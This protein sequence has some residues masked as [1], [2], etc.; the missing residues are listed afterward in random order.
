MEFASPQNVMRAN[1]DF[2]KYGDDSS[3][4]VEFYIEPVH[5]VALSEKEG[6]ALYEDREFIIIQS[7]GNKNKVVRQATDIDKARFSR[8]FA[9]FK[10][11]GD[12]AAIGLPLGEWGALTKAQVL[13]F[14]AMQIHTV[15]QLAGLPDSALNWLGANETR[16]K[17]QEYLKKFDQ[18]AIKDLQDKFDKL[19][20]QHAELIEKLNNKSAEPEASEKPKRKYTKKG[21]TNGVQE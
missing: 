1:G 9:A 8:Q 19:Q 20:T 11:Q 14:K 10:A 5:L 17:A 16:L 7:P 6:R 4:Y 3:L 13:E 21:T 12:Q 18:T 2:A 15:E